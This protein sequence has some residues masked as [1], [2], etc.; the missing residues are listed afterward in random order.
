MFQK[1]EAGWRAATEGGPVALK[2]GATSHNLGPRASRPLLGRAKER[3]GRPRSQE[4]RAAGPH[5]AFE[6]HSH[7]IV[8]GGLLEMSYTT[9][10]MPFTLLMMAVATR[11]SR[12]SGSR[13]QS[14]VMKSSVCTHRRQIA[15]S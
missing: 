4:E 5:S 6:A 1:R 7:S 11:A 12:S 15:F 10:L 2:F 14:A 13:D 8:A 3:A 9:R